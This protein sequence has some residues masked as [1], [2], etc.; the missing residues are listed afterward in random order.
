[1]TGQSAAAA[2]S[3]RQP[4]ALPSN[5]QI[6]S[7]G[8]YPKTAHQFVHRPAWNDRI[9]EI[10]RNAAPGSLLPYGLGRSYGDSCLNAGRELIDCRRLNRMLGFDE[11]TGMLRCESGVSISDIL[12]LF[13]PKG[14]FPP[15]TPGT[16]FVTVG[17]A[18]ANDVHGKNHHCAGSL[19]AHVRQIAL[20]RSNDGLVICNSEKHSD[21]LHATIGGLGL[22]GV[23]AWADIQLKRVDG[24]WINSE[25]IPFHSLASFLDLS[26]ESNDR[27][28]YTVAWL[29]CFAGKNPRGIFFRGNHAVGP[30]ADHGLQHGPEHRPEHG[31]VLRRRREVTLPFALPAWMLNRYSAKAF[32][33]AYYR[34]HAARKGTAIV[35]YDSFFYP[36]DSIRQWNLLYGRRGFLQYQCVIPETNL[37]AIEELIDRIGRSGMGSFLGVLKQFGSAPPAGMLS[38]PRPGLTLA[39]DFAMRGEPTLKLMRSLDEVVQQAGGALY[40]AKDAR[41][42]PGMFEASFPRWR[43][44]VP[45]IDP[46]MS[47]SFWRRVTEAR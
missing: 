19:G 25:F 24:P 8:H 10:M 7:W 34:I 33:A 20:H 26:R 14:W 17:G 35:P 31:K 15:V 9:S 38:F 29:D 27:F 30:N 36:L 39:L 32:N 11:S 22:T 3:R 41:M 47:S 4:G 1:M 46:K 37:E 45:Y 2:A 44:F 40:P 12:D 6:L 13:V 5:K 42:S 21:M 23:I 18:I 43:G 28:E 16:R